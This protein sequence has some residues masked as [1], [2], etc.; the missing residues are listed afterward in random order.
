[1]PS[2]A[3]GTGAGAGEGLETLL[4]RMLL[5]QQVNQQG[6]AQ[7]ET[8]RHNRADEDLTGRNIEAVTGYRNATLA[9]TTA[10]QASAAQD[11]SDRLVQNR[12]NLRPI[13]APVP[14]KEFGEDV[15][16]GVP[17]GAFQFGG[18]QLSPIVPG[19][20]TSE[21]AATANES[22][23]MVNWKGSPAQQVAAQNADTAA[24]NAGKDGADQVRKYTIPG[25]AGVIEAFVDPRDHSMVMRDGTPLPPNAVPYEAPP[26]PTIIQ[27]DNGFARVNPGGGPATPVMDPSGA[28][29][30]PKDP[31]AMQAKDE[32]RKNL[33]PGLN[34]VKGV[35]DRLINLRGVAQRAQA[36]G[37]SVDSA[38]GNN[39]EYRAYNDARFAL[40][41]NLAV[42]QQGS[43]PSDA[44]II[45]GWLPLIPS[46]FND[47]DQSSDIKWQMV[48][49]LAGLP[50]GSIAGR[51]ATTAP[52]AVPQV[53][54]TFNG[55]RVTKVTPLP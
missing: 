44:D 40:A 24:L 19:L 14:V 54:G 34:L 55:G 16:G 38:L 22:N 18:T 36:A 6:E 27:T 45:R 7:R 50:P 3:L 39:P 28:Q 31:A 11:R 53:G 21:Q 43:R 8:A 26:N 42:M 52:G 33:I 23:P 4:K 29:V 32:A 10:N 12:V 51:G 37:Q 9:Q 35:G 49:A 13:D 2:L 46:V 5:E 15:A 48:E 1:M 30:Q 25:R 41:A 20:R 47:T 17:M